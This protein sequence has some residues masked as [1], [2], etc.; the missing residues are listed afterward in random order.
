[1]AD[2]QIVYINI[3]ETGEA[4]L[5]FLGRMSR[6]HFKE[7]SSFCDSALRTR[8]PARLKVDLS[9][10]SYIDAS[11][12]L[13]I[14]QLLEKMEKE[15]VPFEIVY[16]TDKNRRI[17]NLY[18]AALT[19]QPAKGN[20]RKRW[21]I[22]VM[23]GAQAEQ[24]GAGFYK[25]MIFLGEIIRAL[26]QSAFY[27]RSVRWNAVL[28]YIKK[29]GVDG[30]PVVGLI[31]LLVG[32][33]MAFMASLQLKQFG[34]NIY[35]A[36]LVSIAIIKELGPIMTAI[37][38]TGR[39]GSAFAA[40]IGTMMVNEEVDALRTMGFDPN[41]FLVVPKILAALIVVPLLTIYA[42]ILGILGGLIVGVTGLDLTAY[43]YIN[44]TIKTMHA[45]D[46]TWSI[47]KSLFFAFM[48]TTIVC[49][50]GF[51]VR[52]GAEAVGEAATSA[53]VSAI[54]V[55]IIVDSVFAIMFH[56]LNIG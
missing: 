28:D 25:L 55:T 19:V 11:G 21:N 17:I 8:I 43:A 30:F 31:G 2:K 38:I 18:E 10:V 13:L 48:I 33:I 53:V 7:L 34:A 46:I 15:N 22:F 36:S 40:E 29:A 5:S 4:T 47:V 56:Y 37:V 54:F 23:I 1:M 51:Q 45:V 27:P 26:I 52:G 9:S 20:E 32:L 41:R 14:H 3:S 35:V 39:S 24:M 16:G 44:Q 49:Y 50:R 12:V 42:D 6:E